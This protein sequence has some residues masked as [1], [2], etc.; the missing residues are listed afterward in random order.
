MSASIRVAGPDD[1]TALSL[2]RWRWRVD[3][4]GETGSR[5]E[6][7]AAFGAWVVGHETSH[8]AFLA[9]AD[10]LAVGMA[11]LARTDRVPGPSRFVRT[12]GNL[13]SLYV[14]P[15]RRNRGIGGLLVTA[16]LERARSGGMDYVAV[17]PSALSFPL[18]R[19]AGFAE[20]AAVLELRWSRPVEQS[21]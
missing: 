5:E 16:V 9:E 7:T 17:H 10:G 4:G 12:A 15:E 21:V 14:V 11:W 2:L 18:Y 3:E 19:R 13:Q 1:V 6:F 8:T 20:T